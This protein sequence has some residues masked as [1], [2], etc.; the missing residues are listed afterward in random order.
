MTEWQTAVFLGLFSGGLGVA[1]LRAPLLAWVALG[2]LGVAMAS[3]SPGA[4]AVAGG[5]AGAAMTAP[6][7]PTRTLRRLLVLGAVVSFASW[8]GVSAGIAAS[9]PEGERAWAVV[10]VPLFAVVATLPLRLAGAP[11]TATNPLARTQERWLSVVHIARLGSDLCV[12]AALGTSAGVATLLALGG[13]LD[14]AAVVALVAAGL[15][16]ATALGYGALSYRDATRRAAAQRR[17]SVA[18]V[19]CDGA[20]PGG[21]LDGLWPLRSPEY[22]DVDATVERYERHVATA[23]AAGARVIVLPEVAVRVDRASREIWIDAVRSWA[24]KHAVAI[25]APYFDHSRPLNALVVVGPDGLLARYEKQHPGPLE[26]KRS[27]RMPPGLAEVGGPE[28]LALSTVI[29]VDLDYGDL[30]RPVARAGGLLAVPA[31]D[32]PGYELLHHRAA[33]WSAVMSGTSVLRATGHGISAAYDPAGHVL[34]EQSSLSGKGLVVL[35]TQI[36]A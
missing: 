14:R 32:W 28:G 6:S 7:F 11:R 13:P 33:V 34:A 35:V 36:P 27:E 15:L 29:C 21:P 23:A 26:P 17:V 24:K 12:T 3:L 9:W 8:A 19:V 5:V 4:A 18:A 30:V 22:A 2:P 10:A 1:A 25:V 16:L 31:N 20:D